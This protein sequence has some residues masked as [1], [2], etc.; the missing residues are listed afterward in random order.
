[1][2]LTPRGI[3]AQFGHLLQTTLFPAI[4]DE[5]G[6]LSP[7]LELLAAVLA[8]IPLGKFTLPKRG[9]VGH[10]RCDR[11]SLASA[12]LAKAVLNLVDT[13]QLIDR[14][15]ADATLRRLCGWHYASEVP[16]ESTFSRAFTE[17]AD[18][19]LP[20]KLHEAVI[21]ATLKNRLVGHIAR[22]STAIEVR[23]YS[24]PAQKPKPLPKRKRGRPKKGSRP[25]PSRRLARQPRQ[26]L[27]EMLRE[28]PRQC[29]LGVKQ[30]GRGNPYYWDG[31]K[32]HIDV[33]DGGL[34]VSC[35]ITSASV[36]DS[37]AAIPLMTMT[38]SGSS[39]STT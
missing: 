20:Q 34:P 15:R 5:V 35:L 27:P 22:D 16:H 3:V 18:T 14:L 39:L 24:D 19:E 38:A 29:S 33:A 1:M 4:S 7:S 28:L 11:Q 13:R 32:L 6:P 21:T 2:E 10:P 26:T 23:E 25:L 31:Y 17:F 36:R 12:F 37:Q 8:M 30:S 9:Q